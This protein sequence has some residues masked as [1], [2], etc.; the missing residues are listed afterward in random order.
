MK[1]SWEVAFSLVNN[2]KWVDP[3]TF[4]RP[5]F[6][7]SFKD[8]MN[9][10]DVVHIKF[11]LLKPFFE[12]MDTYPLVHAQELLP[13]F[14]PALDEYN[15][16]PGFSMVVFD[17]TLDYFN[18][19][20]QFDLLHCI[21]DAITDIS[22]AATPFEPAII[23]HNYS[24]FLSRLPR[25]LHEKFKNDEVH[26]NITNIANYPRLIK[27]IVEMD[28][29]HV[30]AKNTHGKFYFAGIYGSFPS[31]LDT[32]LKRFGLKIKKF[33]PGDNRL[34]ELNRIFVYQFLME[35][36]GFPI[37]S[38]RRTSA[39]LF[40]RKLFKMGEDFLI[41]VLGQSDRTITTLYKSKESINY[42]K[43]EKIALVKIEKKQKDIIKSLKE[44]NLLISEDPPCVILRVHYRQHSYDPNNIRTDRALS[45]SK[46]EVIN[47]YTLEVTTNYNII[48]D[49]TLMTY[50]LNDIVKGEFIGRIKYKRN[51]IVE[52]TE[53]HEKRLK[54]LYAWLKK[55]QRRILGYSDEFFH[56]ITKVLDNYLLNPDNFEI[57]Q[58][59]ADV[60]QEVWRQYNYI[61]QARKIRILE[62]LVKKEYKGEKIRYL[63]TLT[64]IKE[65]A[66]GFKFDSVIYFEDLM[67]HVIMLCNKVLNDRYLIS[68]YIKKSDNELTDY[69]KKIKKAYGQL[70]A[71]VDDLKKIYKLKKK[72]QLSHIQYEQI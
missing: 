34:Y 30:I 69:G 51:E 70:V 18:E 50:I 42:P 47:P 32:E 26:E 25:K 19:I 61:Q 3:Y 55:H 46:Q 12:N 45:V 43:V 31:D 8:L 39:A 13:S 48:K 9:F 63:E 49:I 38:E 21:E 36:Y 40:A 14:E 22:G 67:E 4:I 53:T 59:H 28:R 64:K 65:I 41:R 35:L 23:Q 72:T 68:K 60:F 7:S 54:F 44:E 15:N 20:F 17:R 16:L 57:F 33:Q 11:C 71:I 1:L 10:L 52:N 2:F 37:A 56:K 27:Y 5:S 58:K 62:E 6:F 24:T 29:A 66:Q